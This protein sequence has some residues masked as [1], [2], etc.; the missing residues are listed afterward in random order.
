MQR[1]PIA[2]VQLQ[3]P[4]SIFEKLE[5]WRRAQSKIPPRS[6]AIRELLRRALEVEQ[7]S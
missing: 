7:S 6:I 1:A 4:P 3:L 5:N 2:A